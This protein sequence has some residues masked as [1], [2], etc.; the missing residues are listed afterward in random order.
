MFTSDGTC[1]DFVQD[2]GMKD[3]QTDSPDPEG[4]IKLA[5]G[6][7]FD[8]TDGDLVMT[9]IQKGAAGTE[10]EIH[11]IAGISCGMCAEPG[12]TGDGCIK[13]FGK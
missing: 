6:T 8:C 7:Q 13:T 2:H 12:C 9:Y 3:G 11:N 5:A 4:R 10:I 1:Y